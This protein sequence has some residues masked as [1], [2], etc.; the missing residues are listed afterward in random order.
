MVT[1]QHREPLLW[2]QQLGDLQL[3]PSSCLSCLPSFT[4]EGLIPCP[5]FGRLNHPTLG[6]RDLEVG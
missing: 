6:L 2:G 5:S 4:S 1:F 3:V